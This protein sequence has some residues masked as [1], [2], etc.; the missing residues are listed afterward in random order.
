MK[1]GDGSLPVPMFTAIMTYFTYLLLLF[2]GNLRD[3]A[4]RFTGHT[5]YP[6]LLPKKGFAPLLKNWESFFTR[7]IYH[8]VQDCWNRPITGSPGAHIRILPRGYN[9]EHTQMHLTGEPPMDCINVG[10]Y[11]Y[12]GFAD[13]WHETCGQT[14]KRSLDEFGVALCSSR[15]DSGTSSVHTQL[16]R[17]VAEF[18]GKEDAVVFNM[19]Y[20]TNAVTVPSFMG[21]GSLIIS[22]ALNHSSIV[23]GARASGACVKVFNH[24]DAENLARVLRE[25][26]A[27]GQPRTHRPWTKILV[28]VEG[29]YSMEG[30]ICDLPAILAVCK[31]YKAYLYVDEAHSI[32][33]VG[34]TGRGVCEHWGVDP[35]EVDILMGTFTKSFGA[36]GGYIA[37]NRE[38]IGYLRANSGGV[39]YNNAMSPVVAMQVLTAL[40]VLHTDVGRDKIRRL[41]ENSDY[42][43][44][45]L[46]AMKC[47]VLGQSGSPVVPL[48]LYVP[49]KVNPFTR[50]CLKRGIAVV[51]VGFP[52]APL[53]SSRARFCISA[54]HTREDIDRTLDVLE[55]LSDLLQLRYSA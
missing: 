40:R 24:N 53:L 1:T 2:V 11:N 22:D 17:E 4:A 45:R 12:L 48:L 35:A 28:M 32:G 30:E 16:E 42:F 36:M 10:S 43:R 33:A 55:E 19:G 38:L 27:E 18:V 20:G 46:R 5:R 51:V 21:R 13:D 34:R 41:A 49:G 50:E 44:D 23:N 9:K 8:R 26:I 31:K 14:V 52:A 37:G 15:G 29:V 47:H 6:V 39:I 54:G 7:R 3:A 25:A